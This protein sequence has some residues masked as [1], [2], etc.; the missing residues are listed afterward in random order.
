MT[1]IGDP[2][3]FTGRDLVALLDSL[4][5]VD[6]DYLEELEDTLRSQPPLPESPWE[7]DPS[8]PVD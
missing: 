6:A 8:Q 3:R 2:G 7:S 5:H 4:P 1:R